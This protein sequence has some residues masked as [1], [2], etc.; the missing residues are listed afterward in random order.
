MS[1]DFHDDW[2]VVLCVDRDK[3]SKRHRSSKNKSFIHNC[4]HLI[5]LHE[6]KARQGLGRHVIHHCSHLSAHN[7]MRS[8][9]KK[10]K[11]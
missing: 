4:D 3:R 7:S 9:I 10:R 8:Y 2:V 11:K 5:F 6:M 1:V